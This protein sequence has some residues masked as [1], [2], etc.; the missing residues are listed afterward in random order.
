[1]LPKICGWMK[2]GVSSRWRRIPRT[3]ETSR[4]SARNK[5][6]DRD[7]IISDDFWAQSCFMPFDDR[8]I[9]FPRCEKQPRHLALMS[10]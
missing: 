2:P 8:P 6:G 4:V 10:A 3:K 5:S 9:S 1:M 7:V